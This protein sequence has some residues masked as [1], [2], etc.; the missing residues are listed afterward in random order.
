LP[1]DPFGHIHLEGNGGG[2]DAEYR[3]F[4]N[5]NEHYRLFEV[6]SLKVKI[7]LNKGIRLFRNLY[8]LLFLLRLFFENKV[9]PGNTFTNM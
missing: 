7:F 2:I 3:T 4:E 6:G 9:S 5:F 8:H 1:T